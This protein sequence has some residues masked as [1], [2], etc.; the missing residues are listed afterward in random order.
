MTQHSTHH[1]ISY[2]GG[3]STVSSPAATAKNTA[4]EAPMLA[5][6]GELGHAWPALL[7]QPQANREL[8]LAIP[9]LARAQANRD[10]ALAICEQA[11]ANRAA[12]AALLHAMQT[13]G[14]PSGHAMQADEVHCWHI[15]A[16]VARRWPHKRQLH[17]A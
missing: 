3:C 5:A 10:L 14:G 9:E 8:A 2:Y 11:Q 13:H 1:G 4:P 12:A 7:A 6:L 16:Q 17:W 15:D